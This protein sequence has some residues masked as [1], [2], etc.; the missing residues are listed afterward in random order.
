MKHSQ[1]IKAGA[2]FGMTSAVITTLGLLVGLA[3]STD[4]KFVVM[5]GLITIAVCDALADALGMHLA[6]E[7]D[8][9]KT[10]KEIWGATISTFLTKFLFATSFVVPVYFLDLSVAMMIDIVWGMLVLFE[11]SYLLAKSRNKNPTYI[12]LEHFALTA[13]VIIIAYQIGLLVKAN[14]N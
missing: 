6:Q 14:F 13:A 4:S 5:G 12:I 2:F 8:A 7:S 9:N 11:G 3:A 1:S 10:A